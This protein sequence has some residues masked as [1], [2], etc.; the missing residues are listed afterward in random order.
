[1]LI[2]K[3][4]KPCKIC[5]YEQK[6]DGGEVESF[7]LLKLSLGE[8]YSLLSQVK[9]K[10]TIENT[11]DGSL[12]IKYSGND[13]IHKRWRQLAVEHLKKGPSSFIDVSKKYKSN[14][15]GTSV[16]IRDAKKHIIR[17]AFRNG[18][19]TNTINRMCISNEERERF[20]Q[21]AKM[22]NVFKID[23]KYALDTRDINMYT[24]WSK[25]I[26]TRYIENVKNIVK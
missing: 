13:E 21:D 7:S 9:N 20:F 8:I 1:M 11:L 26:N 3:L 2:G 14:I 25:F 15:S 16:L 24:Y 23:H 4:I 18:D 22:S 10:E 6:E 12:V 19:D 5:I 17:I